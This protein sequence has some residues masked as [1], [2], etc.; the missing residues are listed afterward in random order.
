MFTLRVLVL[1]RETHEEGAVIPDTVPRFPLLNC[2]SITK[3]HVVSYVNETG[4]K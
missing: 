4:K 2:E 1:L 3:K